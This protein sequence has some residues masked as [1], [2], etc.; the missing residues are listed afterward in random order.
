MVA[1]ISVAVCVPTVMLIWAVP[2]SG[3]AVGTP[4][5]VAEAMIVCAPSLN[6]TMM[7]APVPRLASILDVQESKAQMSPSSEAMR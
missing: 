2:V 4:V 6:G 5:S 7:L 3:V 1:V